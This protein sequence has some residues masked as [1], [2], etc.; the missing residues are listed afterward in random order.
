MA[1][2]IFI[3]NNHILQSL[4]KFYT[5]RTYRIYMAPHKWGNS[6]YKNC[7]PQTLSWQE[8]KREIS[9]QGRLGF[10][11]KI[12]GVLS[13]IYLP[14]GETHFIIDPLYTYTNRSGSSQF[15]SFLYRY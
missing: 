1:K 6:P 11:S 15:V 4:Q 3:K 12:E 14:L 10:G 5:P 7:I 9:Q 2:L 8:K 13:D